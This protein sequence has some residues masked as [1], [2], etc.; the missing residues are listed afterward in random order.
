MAAQI[1][2]GMKNFFLDATL[3]RDVVVVGSPDVQDFDPPAPTTVDYTCKAIVEDY[4]AKYRL[5]GL[6]QANDRKLLVLANSLSVTPTTGDR[7]TIRSQTF[8][9]IMVGVDPALAVWELQ[10][11]A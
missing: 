11:R 7:L 5:E 2:S 8:H 3:T 6:I 9:V 1:H 10:G 4:A